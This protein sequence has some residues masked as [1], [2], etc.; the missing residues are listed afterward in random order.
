MQDVAPHVR[1]LSTVIHLRYRSPISPTMLEALARFTSLKK[2]RLQANDDYIICDTLQA[3]V[4]P[5][6]VLEI[7]APTSGEGWAPFWAAA[8]VQALDLAC[9]RQLKLL[10]VH[11]CLCVVKSGDG[12]GLRAKCEARGIQLEEEPLCTF[13][14][15]VTL[16]DLADLH[17]S[18]RAW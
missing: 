14:L 16:L 7:S 4:S 15:G 6:V 13:E 8:L 10:R 3:I 11:A 18:C 1:N 12:A 2:F 5:L 9:T 17:F